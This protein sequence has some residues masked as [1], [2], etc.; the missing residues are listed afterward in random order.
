MMI[1]LCAAYGKFDFPVVLEHFPDLMSAMKFH[2]TPKEFM[3]WDE[4]VIH[5]AAYCLLD[6]PLLDSVMHPVCQGLHY[7]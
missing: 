4:F 5:Y 6:C 7:G 1:T 2:G 3:T